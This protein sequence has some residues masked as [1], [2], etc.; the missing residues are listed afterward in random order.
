MVITTDEFKSAVRIIS[1]EVEMLG[2]L[3]MVV[4]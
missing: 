3:E 2:E 1:V 4:Q